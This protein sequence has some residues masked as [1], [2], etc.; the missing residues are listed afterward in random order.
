MEELEQLKHSGAYSDYKEVQLSQDQF[1]IPGFI[2]CHTH[3]P[4]FPNLGLGLDRP[5]LEWLA[6]YTFPLEKKYKNAEFAA[7]VYDQVVVSYCVQIL[8]SLLTPTAAN[9]DKKIYIFQLP[10][11]FTALFWE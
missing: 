2:D 5:L 9:P 6:K 1:M 10:Q 3:A 8:T 11:Y 4:Q 7:K